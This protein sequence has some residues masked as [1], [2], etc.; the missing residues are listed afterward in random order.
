MVIGEFAEI[1]P[2][3]VIEITTCAANCYSE[4][5]YVYLKGEHLNTFVSKER[6]LMLAEASIISGMA[7]TIPWVHQRVKVREKR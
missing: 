7:P 2:T 4:Q 6:I 3:E 1:F 5:V